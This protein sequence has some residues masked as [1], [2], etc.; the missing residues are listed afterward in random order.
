MWVGFQYTLNSNDP[1]DCLMILVSSGAMHMSCSSLLVNFMEGCNE[2]RWLVK[3]LTLSRLITTSVSSTYRP[4]ILLRK[5][6]TKIEKCF[7][8]HPWCIWT[9]FYYH[10]M[11]PVQ[12]Q[13]I[14]YVHCLLC[15][16]ETLYITFY[17]IRLSITHKLL[18]QTM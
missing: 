2:F 7:S 6:I 18:N 4:C 16:I 13:D 15:Y 8:H 17:L 9:T 1:S 10:H 12:Q 11:C 14:Q 5:E 3:S